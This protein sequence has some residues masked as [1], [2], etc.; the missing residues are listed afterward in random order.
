V[1]VVPFNRPRLVGEEHA[2]IDE[3][4]AGGKLSG[5]GRF[6]QRCARRLEERLGAPRALI[7]PSC[8]A[9]LEMAAILCDL[10]AGDEVIMPSFTFVSTANAFAL[11]GAIPV[12]VDIRPETLNVDSDLIEA[13][14][15]DRTRAIVVVHYAGVGCEMDRIMGIAEAHGLMVVEDAAHSLPGTWRGQ[16]LGAIGHLATFSFH[17]TKNVHCGEGGALVVNDP[18]LVERAE[19]VQEKGTD[20]ARFFRGEVDKYTWRGI[21]SSYLLSEVAAA[22]LWAQLEHLDEVTAERRGIWA[23]YHDAFAQLERG[24]LIRR[25]VVPPHCVHSGHLYYLLLPDARFRDGF[26]A[27]L[28][29]RGVHAVF[30]YVPLHSSPAGRELGREAN[31]LPVTEDASAR[32]VRLPMWSGLGH[33]VEQVVDAVCD[34]LRTSVARPN[35][36]AN[37]VAA[38]HA[39]VPATSSEP[40]TGSE[41][42]R[43]MA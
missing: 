17:E 9:A 3:A 32:L 35:G 5:N 12:F 33:R 15:T 10:R 41:A 39:A 38:A 6:A 19:I 16:Q 2:Y 1:Q 36:Q 31:A 11:R 43:A 4:L 7:T 25:P 23:Q 37:H 22:F 40:P 27:A 24:Q 21:G 26:I 34:T 28:Q 13:A 8:T 14:V 30:H 18:N 29:T 42:P 20:R